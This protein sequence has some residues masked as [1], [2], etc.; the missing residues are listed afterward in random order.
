MADDIR[1]GP[2]LAG[3]IAT[4]ASIL[5]LSAAQAECSQWD[6]SG[7]WDINWSGSW[8]GLTLTFEQSGSEIHGTGKI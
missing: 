3:L 5:P 6:V 1:F 8:A 7:T 2:A 4:A